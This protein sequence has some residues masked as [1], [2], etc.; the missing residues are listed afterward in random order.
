V[1]ERAELELARALDLYPKSNL[2]DR[3]L[4]RLDQAMCSALS[5][6]AATAADQT[7]ATVLELPEQHRTALIIYRARD[8][9][10]RVPEARMVAEVRALREIL[11]L[12]SE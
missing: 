12:P 4:V 1:T 2:T 6:D 9:A 3:A 8:V 10:C 7:I 5:G 11:S